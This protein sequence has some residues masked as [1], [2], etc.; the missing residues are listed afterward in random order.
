MF[1]PERY[2][3]ED[4]GKFGGTFL[5]DKT[6]QG[7]QIKLLELAIAKF[8]E[9]KFGAGKVQKVLKAA[10]SDGDDQ[11]YAGYANTMALRATSTRRPIVIDQQKTP[12]AKDDNR[13][14]SGD[15]V[16]VKVDLWFQDNKFGKRINCNLLAVQLFK[17]GERFGTGSVSIDDF[18][19]YDN[20]DDF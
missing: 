13:I 10:F 12:L 14:D 16:N 3:G 2:K 9:E 1:E 5:L 19:V 17:Q 6:T 7:D 15:Y 18:D 20:D 8:S 11:S 4:T